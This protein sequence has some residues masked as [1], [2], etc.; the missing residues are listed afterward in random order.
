M[1]EQLALRLAVVTLMS[2]VDRSA[3]RARERST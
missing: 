2:P 3:D 1:S